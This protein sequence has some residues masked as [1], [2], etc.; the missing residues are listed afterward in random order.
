MTH[1]CNLRMFHH[2]YAFFYMWFRVPTVETLPLSCC[3]S[4]KLNL[5]RRS[6]RDDERMEADRQEWKGC[7]RGSERIQWGGCGMIICCGAFI[8]VM[9]QYSANLKKK[10]LFYQNQSKNQSHKAKVYEDMS[11]LNMYCCDT[12]HA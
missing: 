9:F 1:Q 2:A 5:H 6:E 12:S 4:F 7:G 3:D 11:S 10:I 8:N